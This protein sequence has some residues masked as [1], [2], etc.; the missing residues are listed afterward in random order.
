MVKLREASNSSKRKKKLWLTFSY[1]RICCYFIHA[2][3]EFKEE[4][5]R[6]KYEEETG[7]L[8]EERMRQ[9]AEEHRSLME[10]NHQE[11]ARML[12]LR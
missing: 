8:A 9:E 12:K 2:R 10:W 6:K 4:M 3:L 5:L 11:N 7:S 1:P